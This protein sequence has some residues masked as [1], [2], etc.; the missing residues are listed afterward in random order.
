MRR[1]IPYTICDNN[2]LQRLD[3]TSIPSLTVRGNDSL[4]KY[5]IDN[6][7][8]HFLYAKFP[9]NKNFEHKETLNELYG[10]IIAESLEV[11]YRPV[12][13]MKTVDGFYIAS[14]ISLDYNT[15]LNYKK[16]QGTP[17]F[18]S[19]DTKVSDFILRLFTCDTDSN[20]QSIL[21]HQNNTNTS[22]IDFAYCFGYNGN[23]YQ[24]IALNSLGPV[25]PGPYFNEI[26]QYDFKTIRQQIR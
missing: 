3:A 10:N 23:E 11:S 5:S 19:N 21:V 1:N 9:K 17:L 26:K 14:E 6:N 25:Q 24:L 8:T 12:S 13:A 4:W 16:S 18:I 7:S 15:T 22:R 20:D 2:Q